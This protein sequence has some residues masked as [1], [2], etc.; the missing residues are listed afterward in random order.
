VSIERI[1][2]PPGTGKTYTLTQ[3][4]Q[5]EAAKRGSDQLLIGS[6]SVTAAEVLQGRNNLP[7]RQV[8]TL[9][10]HAFQSIGHAPVALDPK[11]IS[12]W[13]ESERDEWHIHPDGRRGGPPV[14]VDEE[15]DEQ[16]TFSAVGAEVENAHT[17]DQLISALD[18]LRSKLVPQADWPPNVLAFAERWEAWKKASGCLDYSDMIANAVLRARDG[19][20]A[21]GNPSVMAFD[22]SQD[23]T[24]LEMSLVTR[25]ARG[26][27]RLILGLD[28]DQSIVTF[29]GANPETLI[30][31]GAD[32]TLTPDDDL[33]VDPERLSDRV[34]GQSFRVPG[35]AHAVAQKWVRKL[36]MR[37]DKAYLPRAVNHERFGPDDDGIGRARVIGET[38]TDPRLIDRIEGHIGAGRTVAVLTSCN[39]HLAPV[40]KELRRRGIPFHNPLRPAEGRW[41]PLGPTAGMS[42]PQRLFRYLVM[43]ERE[44]GDRSRLWT[45]EDVAA[46]LEL[47]DTKRAG[48]ARGAKAAAKRLGGGVLDAEDVAALFDGG[49]ESEHFAAAVEPS[50]DWLASVLLDSKAKAGPMSYALAVA[51]NAGTASLVDTPMV[52]VGTTHCSPADEP[53]LTTEGYVPIGEL[54]PARHRLASYDARTNTPTWRMGWSAHPG[55]ARGVRRD[56][57]RGHEFRVGCNPYRGDLLTLTTSTSRT[58]VTPDHRVRVKWAPEYAGKWALYLMRRGD[59]WRIGISVTAHRPYRSGGVLARM[60][61]E[62]A[63]GGWLLGV[64][65]TR[66]EALTAEA[67]TQARYGVPGYTFESTAQERAVTSDELHAIQESIK[68]YVAPRA[69]ELL[70]DHGLDENDPLFTRTVGRA[71]PG[72]N[73]Q[74][75]AFVIT[76]RNVVPGLM[77]L[78]TLPGEFEPGTK[79]EWEPVGVSR[80][81]F[82]GDVYSLDVVP[83]HYYVS[84]GAIVHNS[85]KGGEADVAIVAPDM[86]RAA[87]A[88]MH[89]PGGKDSV[90]RLMYVALTRGLRDLEILSPSSKFYIR[91]RDLLPTELEVLGS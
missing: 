41:N 37:R 27:D 80:E 23:L 65:G 52:S 21:P 57:R 6:F 22:E 75:Q 13:N 53:V 28:D 60:S 88:Q 49:E 81:E 73:N 35:A 78:P 74:S 36:S 7:K 1:F 76:A 63:D 44:L 33:W 40:I 62:Q 32:P 83:H 16:A 87:A 66:R 19:E 4:I 14:E 61:S 20:R 31:L 45:G 86:S 11:V 82:E 84:G 47:V 89:R 51:R 55:Q 38:L 3:E 34:L 54:D 69:K 18:L 12:D 43:D 50:I 25:W 70:R 30:M 67:I 58:R 24:P 42:T 90:I 5:A 77:L 79:P 8:G 71:A 91:T 2:G 39:F 72:R 9:H 59:W 46:W 85:Y 17:G 10:K 26:V 48:L 56:V 64:Y 68:G 29:R 15:N